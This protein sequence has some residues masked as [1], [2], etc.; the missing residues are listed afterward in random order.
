ML[1]GVDISNW[2]SGLQL[3]ALNVD[4]VIAKAS[5]GLYFKDPCFVDF[6]RQADNLKLLTGAYHFANNDNPVNQATYFYNTIKSRI[7]KTLP[8]LDIETTAI[9]NWGA[10]ADA[11]TTEFHKLSGVWP[12]VYTSAGFL[13]VYKGCNVVDN[14]ALWL[15]GYPRSIA[16]WNDGAIPYNALPWNKAALW[17]FTGQGRLNGYGGN[18]DLD[19]CYIT[20]KQW[21]ALASGSNA[22]AADSKKSI[23]TI[24]QEV[25]AGKWSAGQARKSKLTAAGYDYA[26]V[27]QRVNE[28]LK[29]GSKDLYSV[30]REVIAGKWSAGQARIDKLKAAGYN[31]AA[32][33]KIVN[34]LMKKY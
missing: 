13:H 17:Q 20:A 33:Q 4:F 23:D 27:Q 30:A 15:A 1:K 3:K 8:A 5:E 12:M 31:P 28:L 10:F 14:C 32:V 2:Q 26:K 6:M 19:W 34:E 7:G 21:Q 11:F 29:T 16:T 24:A 25:I 22:P 9:K 18:L